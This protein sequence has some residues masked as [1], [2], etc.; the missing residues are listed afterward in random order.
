M[1]FGPYPE[2]SLR[3]AREK[4]DEAK[5]L[6][7]EGEDPNREKKRKKLHSRVATTFL[8]IA[9]EYIAKQKNT[10]SSRHVKIVEGRLR[11]HVYPHIGNWPIRE[12][13]ATDIL[14]IIRKAE[15]REIFE[16]ANRVH[17]ICSRVFRYGVAIG[18]V[19][20]D[21][22]RDLKGALASY[23]K[24]HFASLTKPRDVGVLMCAIDEYNG[25][26]VVRAALR[27]SALTFCRPGE[28]RHA[29]WSEIDFEK[30]EWIIPAAKMKMRIK[31]IVP[32]SRQ[33]V[34]VLKKIHK[35]T[36]SGKYIFPGPRK[37]RP[38][39]ENGVNVAIRSMGYS[40]D[41]MTAHG[42]RSMAS[43]LLNE[44]DYNGDWI[45]AQL[46]HAKKGTRGIYNYA[47]YLRG[48]RQM[49]QWWADYLDEL[50]CSATSGSRL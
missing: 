14:A 30:R 41:Q 33:S 27:F 1:S 10:W 16:T 22:C 6:L 3:E 47:I 15:E 12:I 19:G 50:R 20:S 36:G 28:I 38:L 45:E 49:M 2:I 9:S 43:T 13:G 7:R 21:P 46:A 5:K 35:T 24:S 39:S 11:L 31:H 42:F 8:S 17:G 48:R 4:R 23:E 26:D 18:A 32:L 29:E 44:Q 34:E 40:G 25:S 37:Q